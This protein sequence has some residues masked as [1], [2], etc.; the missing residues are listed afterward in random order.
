MVASRRLWA[1]R[2]PGNVTFGLFGWLFADLMFALAM[3]FL[4][5]TTVG[6]PSPSPPSPTATPT[7]TG[8]PS[9]HPTRPPDPGRVLVLEPVTLILTIDWKGVLN[10]RGPAVAALRKR[11]L[12]DRRLRHRSAGLVQTFGGTVGVG[13][14]TGVNIAKTVNGALLQACNRPG[15][16]FYKARHSD[17]LATDSPPNILRIDVYL[18]KQ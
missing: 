2:D 3:A 8:S 1:A 10:G 9:H 15:L 4:V 7:Q 11:V 12:S 14:A 18:F 17:F 5:A 6:Q 16:V 13:N